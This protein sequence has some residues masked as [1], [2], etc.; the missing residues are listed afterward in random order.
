M[1][2]LSDLQLELVASIFILL[3]G[4]Y[5]LY[6]SFNIDALELGAEY[7][8]TLL[9][10]GWSIERV[11]AKIRSLDQNDLFTVG[12]SDELNRYKQRT[13]EQEKNRLMLF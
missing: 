10:K 6:V 7:T 13:V 12:M 8:K 1:Y 9:A 2:W 5:M 3:V 11:E 4:A